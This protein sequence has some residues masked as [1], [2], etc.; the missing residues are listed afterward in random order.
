MD[1]M[2]WDDWNNSHVTGNL[3][4]VPGIQAETVHKLD[5]DDIEE[6]ECITSAH[7]LIGKFLM[8]SGPDEITFSDL[9]KKFSRFLQERGITLHR[10]DIVHAISEKASSFFPGFH[11]GVEFNEDDYK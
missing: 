6:S 3:Y 4:E 7:Q 5:N 2:G 1:I 9:S 11:D 10:P 8:L